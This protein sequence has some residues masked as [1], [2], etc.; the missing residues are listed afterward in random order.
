MRGG[1]MRSGPIALSVF[2]PVLGLPFN[3]FNHRQFNSIV[4]RDADSLRVSVCAFLLQRP[5]RCDAQN[6]TG[7]LVVYGS[8]S[9]GRSPTTDA[10]RRASSFLINTASPAHAAIVLRMRPPTCPPQASLLSHSM[11]RSGIARMATPTY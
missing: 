6:K 3:V 9:G 11:C 1:A 4:P 10:E 5:V 8:L 2:V 7:V